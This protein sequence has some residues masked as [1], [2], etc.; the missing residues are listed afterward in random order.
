MGTKVILENQINRNTTWSRVEEIDIPVKIEQAEPKVLEG[1]QVY[2]V[3]GQSL[4]F[5]PYQTAAYAPATAL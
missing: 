3:P 4:I 2:G 5:L 1:I